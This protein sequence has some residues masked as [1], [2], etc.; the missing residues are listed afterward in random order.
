VNKDIYRIAALVLQAAETYKVTH[1]IEGGRKYNVPS[2]NI[3]FDDPPSDQVPL[4]SYSQVAIAGADDFSDDDTTVEDLF[5][6]IV[7]VTREVSPTCEIF[8]YSFMSIL[9]L[10]NPESSRNHFEHVVRA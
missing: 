5:D 10:R 2:E 4:T 6:D 1:T 7:G 3:A 9:L 8:S